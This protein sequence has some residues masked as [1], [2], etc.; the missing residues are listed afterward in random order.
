MKWYE[1]K[2]I[3]TCISDNGLK[4]FEIK[5]KEGAQKSA[6]IMASAESL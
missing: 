5:Q 3:N 4:H 2:F 1:D 6:I